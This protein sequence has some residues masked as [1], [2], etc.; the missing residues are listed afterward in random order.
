MTG[1]DANATALQRVLATDPVWTGIV[2]AAEVV[3]ADRVLFHAGPPFPHWDAVPLP[4]RNS[5]A[6]A[7]VYEGW[8]ATSEDALTA[9]ANGDIEYR[10]AQD[11][12]MVVPLCGVISPSMALHVVADAHSARVKYA[13]LNEGM[14]HCLRLGTDDREIPRFHHW[15][16]G[17]YARYLAR[18]VGTPVRLWPF[19]AQSHTLGDD[20]HSRTVAASGLFNDLLVDRDTP[21]DVAEFLGTCGAFALNL[22]M[23]A[24]AVALTAAEGVP[25]CD[26]VT[27]AGGNGSQFGIQIAARPGQW[28]TTT[29]TPPQGPIDAH[30]EDT[31]ILG[32]IGDSAVVDVFGLGGQ[33]LTHAPDVRQALAGH[34]PS[35]ALAR[36]DQLLPATLEAAGG[37]RTGLSARAVADSGVGPI[38]LLGLISAR[39]HG[40]V[41]GGCYQ[42]P[43]G[44]FSECV[45]R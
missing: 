33:S 13:A 40:R 37:L 15:L 10:A 18:R 7:A 42:P 24:A 17:D 11:H 27:R 20:G 23:A 38:V 16:N 2:R 4:V 26:L 28:I 41:G 29:A 45:G 39:G 8:S 35:D 44:L 36:P 1:T 31:E 5:M 43:I 22:W 3:S 32:A 6:L 30:L 21:S 12:D 14:Q 9:L 34:L 19:L 25:D